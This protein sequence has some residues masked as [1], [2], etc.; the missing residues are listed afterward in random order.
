MHERAAACYTGCVS[1]VFLLLCRHAHPESWMLYLLGAAVT[2]CCIVAL[3]Q[4]TGANPFRLYP[5]GMNYFD[6]GKLYSGAYLGTI[7][8]TDLFSSVLCLAIPLFWAS[9]WKLKDKRRFFLL[10]PLALCL[11]VLFAISVA[12]GMVGVLGALLLSLPVLPRSRKARLLLGC[13][14]GGALFLGLLSVYFMG[15]R[16]GGP[17]YELSELMHGRWND[18]FGTGRL[19]IWRNA[20][21]LLPERLLLG[22]GPDTL[23]LRITEAFERYDPESKILIRGVIDDAHNIYLNVLLNQGLPA[24][25]CWLG[26]LAVSAVR[27]VRTASEKPAVAVCGTAVLCWCI[28]AFFNVSSV[29]ATPFFWIV[30]ALLCAAERE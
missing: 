25:L 19:F 28:Q 24:L 13:A 1:I 17:A 22:S 8:N 21:A 4:L 12:G 10:I 15:A 16:I 7:G 23:G 27:W 2:L 26:A 11:F 6:A 3:I 30:F 18:D 14:V 29:V 9:V 20:A 5:E